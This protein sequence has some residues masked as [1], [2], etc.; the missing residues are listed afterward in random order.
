MGLGDQSLKNWKMGELSSLVKSGM[1]V[2]QAFTKG[3][4][5][6]YS[7]TGNCEPMAGGGGYLP[8]P[9]RSKTAQGT[10]AVE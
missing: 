1:A 6:L 9:L 5:Q 2:L 4:N 3:T 8:Q 7:F 10:R